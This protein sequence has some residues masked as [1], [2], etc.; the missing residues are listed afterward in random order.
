MSQRLTSLYS[1]DTG[2]ILRSQ[3]VAAM[4]IHLLQNHAANSPQLGNHAGQLGNHAPANHTTSGQQTY[5]TPTYPATEP[6]YVM[7]VL[8]LQEVGF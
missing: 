4:Q 5:T 1:F 8:S 7:G 6:R 3:T 2:G